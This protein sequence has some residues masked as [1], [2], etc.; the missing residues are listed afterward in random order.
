M[1]Q[2]ISEHAQRSF[3]AAVRRWPRSSLLKIKLFSISLNAA[4]NNQLL[5]RMLRIQRIH[6]SWLW[7]H[8]KKMRF[9]RVVPLADSV[10][11]VM[12]PA[13][14]PFQISCLVYNELKVTTL[15]N[16]SHT[17]KKVNNSSSIS[18]QE[19]RIQETKSHKF[20]HVHCKRNHW[21]PHKVP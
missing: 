7:D 19:H 14:T 18:I 10:A 11:P 16:T 5:L 20:Q 12:H 8:L 1:V 17:C 4:C 21:S 2:A 9:D 13:E 6:L 15:C 3:I